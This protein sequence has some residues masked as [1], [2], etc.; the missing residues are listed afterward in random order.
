MSAAMPRL[1][2]NGGDDSARTARLNNM[3]TVLNTR[4]PCASVPAG[5]AALL[6]D[7]GVV[8]QEALEHAHAVAAQAG[9]PVAAAL[10]RLGILSERE[11]AQAYSGLLQIPLARHAWLTAAPRLPDHCNVLYLRAKRVL[12]IGVHD[13]YVDLAMADPCDDGAASAIAFLYRRPVHRFAA[14]ETDIDDALGLMEGSVPVD[15]ALPGPGTA[16][17]DV[18]LLHDRASDAPVI[19]L[20]N[21]WI[22]SAVELAASDIHIE[23]DQHALA[24]RMRV[25]GMLI[26][27]ET[28]SPRWAD[29]VASRIKLMAKL[30]IAEKRVPQDGRIKLAVRGRPVEL[31]VAT[32][33]GLYGEFVVLRV[34]GQAAVELDL[35]KLE[36]PAEGLMQLR[37]AL[38]KPHGI[39]LLT[40]PTGSGKTTTLYAALNALR[41]PE[42]KLVTVE[43]PVEYSMSGVSQLQV[44]PEIGLTYAAALRAILRNDPDIVMIGEIRDKETADIAIRAALTGHLVLATLHTNTAA[45]AVT[46]LL[47][48]G[49]EDF[50]LASTLALCAAQRLVRKLCTAC[51]RARPP[52]AD[53]QAL[54]LQSAGGGVVPEQLFEP[55]GC[56][57]CLGRGYLGRTA[58]FEAISIDAALQDR[59]RS[60]FDE[61]AFADAALGASAVDLWRHGL[62]KVANG[63]TT[64]EE[65]LRVVAPATSCPT[66]K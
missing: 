37:A 46:R 12:P 49:V 15:Q 47:D 66:S 16:R 35:D 41:T 62:R 53:E 59:I 43:D 45:G 24:V 52:T 13:G 3:N 55:V 65:L 26:E 56:V 60:H 20:V 4:P 29:P 10:T 57:R 30:D 54:L 14:L 23:P 44:K 7:T 21:R 11:L 1:R 51:A 31:R 33:P 8:T 25:D 48:L 34:L 39:V 18:A 42:R 50:L 63:L 61:R 58:L 36:L 28:L 64:L 40:G 5:L 27:S 6:V 2:S 32:F 9:V 38:G 19:R 17:D 22:A